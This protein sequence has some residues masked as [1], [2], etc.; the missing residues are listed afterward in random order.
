MKKSVLTSLIL[1]TAVFTGTAFAGSYTADAGYTAADTSAVAGDDSLSQGWY[2]GAGINKTAQNNFNEN[3]NQLEVTE[4][5]DTQKVGFGL[6]VGKHLNETFAAELGY[7][8]YGTNSFTAGSAESNFYGMRSITAFGVANTPSLAGVSA[9]GKLG[10]AY[11]AENWKNTEDGVSVQSGTYSG[12]NLAYGFGLQYT[13]DRFAVSLD[14]TR[15]EV[16]S[17]NSSTADTTSE[18]Y[19]PDQYSLN[20]IYNI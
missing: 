18:I 12:A 16:Q 8:S 7:N 2:V 14:W 13:F 5:A 20:F 19:A 1:A 6:L 10:A 17:G 9:H 4:Q 15:I 11:F 3:Y